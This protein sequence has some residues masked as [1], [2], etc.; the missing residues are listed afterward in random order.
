MVTEIAECLKTEKKRK[1]KVEDTKKTRFV[2][3][4]EPPETRTAEET[5]IL[6]SAGDWQ[7]QADLKRQLTFPPRST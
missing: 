7:M 1:K 6:S 3:A 5:G 4:G 2:R